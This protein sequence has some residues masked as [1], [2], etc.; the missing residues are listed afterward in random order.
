MTTAELRSL[1]ES[2]DPVNADYILN[3]ERTLNDFERLNRYTNSPCFQHLASIALSDLIAGIRMFDN[4]YLTP[5]NVRVG[6]GAT[7]N[8]WSDR[9]AGTIVKVTKT[10]ITIRRDKATLDPDFKPEWIIGGFAGHCTNQDEQTYTYEPNPNG[11]LI[12]LHWSK[13]YNRYGQPGDLTASKG[14]HEFYDY[15]F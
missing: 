8:Y 5:A 4:C 2:I 1:V 7:V 10:T 9:H 13:K 12:T 14:R 15:N 11:E 3:T 6:Q